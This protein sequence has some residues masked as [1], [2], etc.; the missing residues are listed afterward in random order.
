MCQPLELELCCAANLT[1]TSPHTIKIYQLVCHCLGFLEA[2]RRQRNS[3]DQNT[4]VSNG[5]APA[6][7]HGYL[8]PTPPSI[9]FLQ[10][11]RCPHFNPHGPRRLERLFITTCA[12]CVR[13]AHHEANETSDVYRRSYQWELQLHALQLDERLRRLQLERAMAALPWGAFVRSLASAAAD[14]LGRVRER[15]VLSSASDG[16]RSGM[17]WVRVPFTGGGGEGMG[18]GGDEDWRRWWSGRFG[19]EMWEFCEKTAGPQMFPG[20]IWGPCA[21]EGID[22]N[23]ARLDFQV[24]TPVTTPP[25]TISTPC[26][27]GGSRYCYRATND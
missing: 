7:V 10:Q 24:L 23:Q 16:S 26:T 12:A 4:T 21:L 14:E 8:P 6:P 19:E 13:A 15:W 11:L 9:Q 5:V 1:N 17:R 27:P 18:E 3:Q 25:S 20:G 22:M 2:I